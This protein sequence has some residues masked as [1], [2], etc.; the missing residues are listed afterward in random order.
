M[1]QVKLV[2]TIFQKK[3]DLNILKS[4]PYG[5]LTWLTVTFC[6]WSNSCDGA[7]DQRLR[8]LWCLCFGNTLK[9]TNGRIDSLVWLADID[10]RRLEW[11]CPA[12]VSSPLRTFFS[13]RKKQSRVEKRRATGLNPCYLQHFDESTTITT[14]QPR[15]GSASTRQWS[16]EEPCFDTCLIRFWVF[17]MALIPVGFKNH[18]PK[19]SL[20]SW[21]VCTTVDNNDK[22]IFTHT[23]SHCLST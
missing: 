20:A 13:H 15:K 8:G 17:V 4:C 9:L 16:W 2:A 11:P 19:P 5:P 10:H 22:E 23:C 7:K 18:H 1:V 12:C 14:N 21:A 6:A 3:H